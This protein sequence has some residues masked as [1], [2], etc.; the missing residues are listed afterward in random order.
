MFCPAKKES[1]FGR[2]M[3]GVIVYLKNYLKTYVHQLVSDCNFGIFIQIDKIVFGTDRDI[4]LA[5]IY[6]PPYN[7][8]F[9]NNEELS[10]IELLE[11]RFMSLPI[12]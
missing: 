7:S 10:G 4:V 12:N 9:Y 6:I 3:G 5:F 11:H 8:P 2:P 1:K